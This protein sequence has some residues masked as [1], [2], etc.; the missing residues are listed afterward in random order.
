MVQQAIK[1][2]FFIMPFLFGIGFIAPL[3]AELMKLAG[4]GDGRKEGG[5]DTHTV[6]MTGKRS[7]MV[8]GPAPPRCLNAR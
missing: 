5:V 4:I 3:T 1:G 7:Q 8:A 6:V 2:I